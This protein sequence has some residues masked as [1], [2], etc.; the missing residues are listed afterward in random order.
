[1]RTEEFYYKL[2][3]RLIAQKPCEIRDH[4]RMMIVNRERGSV[5]CGYFCDI[6]EFFEKGDVLVINDSKVIPARLFGS[7]ST[8]AT[9][10]ILLLKK[11]GSS[12]AWETLLRPAKRVAVGTKIFFDD[13]SWAEV[14]ERVSEKKW[15]LDFHT[16]VDFDLFLERQGKAPLP[17]YIK[18]RKGGSSYISDQERYQTIYARNPGS[19]AA[20]TAGL[21]F[22]EEI[23]GKLEGR[24]VDIARVTLHVGYGTFLPIETEDVEDHVMEKEF[25]EISAETAEKIN[26]ARRITATG[27][28]SVRVLES[29]AETDGAVRPATGFTDLFIYP[30]Y[31]FKRI[32]RLLTNFHLPKSSLFLLV[33]AFAVNDL[34][35]K[36]Y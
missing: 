4:S 6:P 12:S 26:T 10:E 15:V 35:Q 23:I 34:M 21:H 29:V 11:Q 14:S 25:F 5:E 7:K 19:V 22:S 28:T 9:I 2:P 32:D 20:P 1:M 33:C 24:G 31:R 3:Q 13:S 27:T 36:A 17:P 18:R 8:G 16:D 30:G